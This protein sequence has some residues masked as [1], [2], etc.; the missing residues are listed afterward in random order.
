MEKGLA[1]ADV[2]ASSSWLYSAL[3]YISSYLDAPESL[4]ELQEDALTPKLGYD[5]H[6]IV[7]QSSAEADDYPRSR[8]DS[9]DNI[10]RVPRLKHWEI[11]A[12]YQTS[13]PDYGDL[14]PRDYLRGKDWDERRRVG[15]MPL[16]DSGC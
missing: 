13:N 8:I 9:A 11:N 5:R 12:W 3:P 14:S 10:V 7:E 1:V 4:V 16:G 15:W 6:H 2:V